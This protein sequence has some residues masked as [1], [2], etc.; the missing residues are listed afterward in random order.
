[1]AVAKGAAITLIRPATVR[2]SSRSAAAAADSS[3][4]GC[5]AEVIGSIF[6]AITWVLGA[7]AHPWVRGLGTAFLIVTIPLLILAGYCM[8]WM[9]RDRNKSEV[10]ESIKRERRRVLS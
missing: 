9:E 8:D 10:V 7:A 2:A 6:T 3:A 4:A 1:M 5:W